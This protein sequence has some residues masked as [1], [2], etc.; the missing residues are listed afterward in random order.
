MVAFALSQSGYLLA[1][2]LYDAYLLQLGTASTIA[3]LS[4]WPRGRLF[5]I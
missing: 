2:G 3:K 4:G 1:T 5:V